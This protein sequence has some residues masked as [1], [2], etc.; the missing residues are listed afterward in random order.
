MST[1]TPR[2]PRIAL[3]WRP[4]RLLRPWC[5]LWYGAHDWRQYLPIS[6]WHS[7]DHYCQRCRLERPSRRQIREGR[8]VWTEYLD[9]SGRVI[10]RRWLAGPPGSNPR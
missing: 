8:V 4:R 10:E 7:L 5:R 3:R 9:P 2:R 1:R 6:A